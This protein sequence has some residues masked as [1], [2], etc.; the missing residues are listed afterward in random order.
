MRGPRLYESVRVVGSQLLDVDRRYND[1]D[2]DVE[3]E[4]AVR[5]SSLAQ[6]RQMRRKVV[7]T[8]LT[9]VDSSSLVPVQSAATEY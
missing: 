4:S 5:Q 2:Y 9:R 1:R 3:R 7:Y 6:R 8:I